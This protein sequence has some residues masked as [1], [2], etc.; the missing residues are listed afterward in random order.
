M[1]SPADAPV[2]RKPATEWRVSHDPGRVMRLFPWLGVWA[3]SPVPSWVFTAAI[4]SVSQRVL[5]IRDPPPPWCLHSVLL[6]LRSPS[7]Q[8]LDVLLPFCHPVKAIFP[9]AMMLCPG[10]T[11]LSAFWEP[12]V[13]NT[14]EGY[15]RDE[16]GEQKIFQD[17]PDGGAQLLLSQALCQRVSFRGGPH[18]ISVEGAAKPL[19]VVFCS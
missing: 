2:A 1:V 7:F 9:V 14:V 18:E 12:C 17:L 8:P 10:L 11:S 3:A 13:P 19:R 4:P 6:W 15:R 5:A 16:P